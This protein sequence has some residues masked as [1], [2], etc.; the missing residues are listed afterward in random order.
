MSRRQRH[1][2]RDPRGE[3]WTKVLRATMEEPAWRA[4]SSTAQALYPWLKLEWRGPDANNNGKLRL[5]VRQ[6]AEKM[7]VVPDTAAKAFRDLQRKGFIVQTEQACLGVDGA[8]KAPAYEITELKMPSAERDGRMLYR[9]WQKGTDFPVCSAIP[10]NPRGSNGRKTKPRHEN[11]DSPVMKT[12]TKSADPVLK[13]MT[14]R[15]KNHDENAI[16]GDQT[17]M[18]SMTS[19]SY[20]TSQEG[21]PTRSPA[22]SNVQASRAPTKAANRAMTKEMIHAVVKAA[23]MPSEKEAGRAG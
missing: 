22:P 6:A 23:S 7:G 8:A 16:S 2:R 9:E 21:G 1:V 11:H 4:L 18:K 5:S 13:S 15:P 20:Q 3:H 14:A 17:V 19:L 12:M 10:N